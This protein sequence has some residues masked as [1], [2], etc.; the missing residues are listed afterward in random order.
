MKMKKKIVKI[1]LEINEDVYDLVESY[2]NE[3]MATTP[4]EVLSLLVDATAE[5]AINEAR[6]QMRS[7]SQKGYLGSEN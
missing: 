3:F 4:R 6:R 2:C 7:F 1:E 5:T